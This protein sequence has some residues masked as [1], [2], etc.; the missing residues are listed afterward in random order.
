MKLGD[1]ITARPLFGGATGES[2]GKPQKGVVVYIHPQKR[3]YTLEFKSPVTG[4]FQSTLPLR[5]ATPV[6]PF[7]Y[8]SIC[9]SIHAPLAGSDSKNTQ[10]QMRI[11][12]IMY[13][14][15]VTLL[16]NSGQPFFAQ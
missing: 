8:S 10:K 16:K 9:I 7:S 12:A 3:F 14:F 11:S 2:V 15:S 1:Q 6:F 5:G 13:Y 4:E